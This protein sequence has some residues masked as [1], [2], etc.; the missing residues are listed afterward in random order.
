[1]QDSFKLITRILETLFKHEHARL[2]RTVSHLHI[3]NTQRWGKL[4]DGYSYQGIFFIPKGTPNG[5]RNILPLHIDLEPEA[6][7][8]ILDRQTIERDSSRIAQLLFKLYEP[9]GYTGHLEQDVR[10]ATP[11][12]ILDVMSEDIRAL[13]RMREPQSLLK[14]PRDWNLYNE[15]LPRI[16]FYS[17]ARLLY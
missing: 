7:D 17:A 10:D 2:E 15:T 13:K 12:C 9:C 3:S 8:H 6:A 1:M 5:K 11:D 4:G 14:H 16:E